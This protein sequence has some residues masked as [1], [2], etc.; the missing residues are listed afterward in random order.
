MGTLSDH[1]AREVPLT[2]S[3]KRPTVNSAE[4]D[5]MNRA[6]RGQRL[7]GGRFNATQENGVIGQAN[8]SPGRINARI[9]GKPV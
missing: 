7:M 9:N 4:A 6:D 8:P 3:D 1:V 5:L 2:V